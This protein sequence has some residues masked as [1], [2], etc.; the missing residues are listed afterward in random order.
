MGHI[1]RSLFFLPFSRLI[2]ALIEI[3]SGDKFVRAALC[4]P[5]ARARTVFF[6]SALDTLA[7]KLLCLWLTQRRGIKELFY[8]LP[9]VA[10]LIWR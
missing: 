6:S 5:R 8:F 10:P 1:F 3:R 2:I 7:T 4:W 9:A